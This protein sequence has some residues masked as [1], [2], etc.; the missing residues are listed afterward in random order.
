M[1]NLPVNIVEA[2]SRACPWS[3]SLRVTPQPHVASVS[4]GLSVAGDRG[5]LGC[6]ILGSDAS[7]SGP[8]AVCICS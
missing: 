2:L 1:V 3:L 4:P 8:L 7:F 6:L 5:P